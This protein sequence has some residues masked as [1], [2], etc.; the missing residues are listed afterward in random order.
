MRAAASKYSTKGVGVAGTSTGG[1]QPT[2][3]A[4][5][6]T[7]YLSMGSNI[8]DRDAHLQAALDAVGRVVMLDRVSAVYD[9]APLLVTDQPR[10]HNVVCAGR[11]A[12]DPLA[13]LRA[14]KAIEVQRGRVAGPR[15]GPRVLDIDL[16]FYDAVVLHSSE[17]TLPHPRIAERAFVLRPLAEIAPQLHH[18]VLGMSIAT[19]AAGV[20][21]ADVRPLGHL[22]RLAT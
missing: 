6:H 1:E 20:A 13:L 7:V 22:L 2:T 5:D 21:D 8:G 12:L 10:F 15:Y 14:V 3:I 18:P 11:T 9:T 17:L 16:L 4:A 19:L